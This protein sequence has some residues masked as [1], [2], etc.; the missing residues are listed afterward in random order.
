M[1]LQVLN[2][3]PIRIHQED[4]KRHDVN[5]PL[6]L[7]SSIG[8]NLASAEVAT[9]SVEEFEFHEDDEETYGNH[10][11]EGYENSE[12]ERYSDE[13]REEE[14]VQRGE[15][16]APVEREEEAPVEREEEAPVEKV[17]EAPTEKEEN[18][19][20][21]K[22]AA[23]GNEE[24][25]KGKELQEKKGK[26]QKELNKWHKQ[27][28]NGPL[29]NIQEYED[30]LEEERKGLL[31]GDKKKKKK[32][33]KNKKLGSWDIRKYKMAG[34]QENEYLEVPKGNTRWSRY[35]NEEHIDDEDE[36]DNLL[37]GEFKKWEN[38]G[39]HNTCSLH[40]EMTCFD[41]RLSDSE[42]NKELKEME[43]FPKKHELISLY[44]QSFLNERSKYINSNRCLSKKLLELKKKQNFETISGYK[45]KWKKCKQIVGN[46]FKEQREH[47]NDI[48]YTSVVKENLSRDEF[49]EILKDVRDSWK[50]VTLKVTQECVALFGKPK[51]S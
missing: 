17:E 22:G 25:K 16:E 7:H 36:M 19:A 27:A 43:K 11:E 26:G 44:W 35:G 21:K 28:Y 12:E 45:N 8:R 20:E 18:S 34:Y 47:V 24:R 6:Q 30:Q 2:T 5:A 32:N 50:E 40:Y 39:T 4:F 15:E 13:E 46:N 49:K 33:G 41:E 38:Y 3:C 23:G 48:F 31:K 29:G 10:P 14:V 51:L 1:M 42:I 9:P 37:L